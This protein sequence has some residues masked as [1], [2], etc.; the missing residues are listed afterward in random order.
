MSSLSSL[1]MKALVLHGPRDLRL[2]H[3]P[4]PSA[5]PASIIVRVQADLKLRKPTVQEFSLE[6]YE[7]AMKSVVAKSS[8]WEKM[9]IF[10][11]N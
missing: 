5:G 7:I 3:V 10:A 6:E 1:S 4:K 2:D 8:G 9:A 11:M